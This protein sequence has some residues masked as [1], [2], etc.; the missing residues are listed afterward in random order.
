MCSPSPCATSIF[1]SVSVPETICLES[2]PGTC[3]GHSVAATNT[4][5]RAWASSPRVEACW[6]SIHRSFP[7]PWLQVYRAPGKAS[8]QKG[9]AKHSRVPHFGVCSKNEVKQAVSILMNSSS[10]WI[11]VTRLLAVSN[12]VKQGSLQFNDLFLCTVLSNQTLGGVK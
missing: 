12:K 8:C 10:T 1:G 11:R 4:S 6:L 2:W 3:S 9:T 7:V 5:R